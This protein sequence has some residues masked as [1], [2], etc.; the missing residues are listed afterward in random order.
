MYVWQL[1]KKWVA[2]EGSFE[3]K[4]QG[5]TRGKKTLKR[6]TPTVFYNI[7]DC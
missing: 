1:H 6:T 5:T 3:E 2:E 4:L 7:I